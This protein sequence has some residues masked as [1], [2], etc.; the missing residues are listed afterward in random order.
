MKK[1]LTLIFVI[2]TLSSIDASAK[3]VQEVEL[4]DGTILVGYVY[5]QRPSMF[6]VFHAEYARK[7][8]HAAYIQ[9]DTDYTLQWKDI[10]YIRRS[11]ESDVSWYNDKITLYD[12]TTYIGQI[13]EQ[14]LGISL[15]IRLNNS[16]KKIKVNNSELQ[17]SEKTSPNI[18]KNLWI[19]K[20]YT[21]LLKLTDNSIHEGLIILQYKGQEISDCYVE[22]LHGSGF[23]ERIYLPDISEYI[24]RLE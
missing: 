1:I 11:A 4:K 8:P 16:G 18:D 23:K 22:L 24:I 15:T 19:D 6:V 12:G 7:D 21:N 2:I 13:E 17:M 10:K 9:H 20:Q 5:R 14:E 3:F